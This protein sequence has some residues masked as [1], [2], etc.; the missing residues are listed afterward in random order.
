MHQQLLEVFYKPRASLLLC[1]EG[2]LILLA[3]VATLE[4][5]DFALRPTHALDTG[6]W[7]EREMGA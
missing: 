3:L 5:F 6:G 4:A 1:P 2:S 7:V